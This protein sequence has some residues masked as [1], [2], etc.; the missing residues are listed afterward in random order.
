MIE[1]AAGGACNL[2]IRQGQLGSKVR[3]HGTPSSRR[4]SG[5][6][7]FIHCKMVPRVL[8]ISSLA[9]RPSPPYEGFLFRFRNG[10]RS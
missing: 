8:S 9:P 1:V 3:S 5:R 10:P 6:H 4:I 2:L 7:D